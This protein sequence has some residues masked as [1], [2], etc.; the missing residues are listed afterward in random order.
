MQELFFVVLVDFAA[1]W[2]GNT[3][4]TVAVVTSTSS[5]T[6]DAAITF[7]AIAEIGM[8]A[9]MT[10]DKGSHPS[11]HININLRK[12]LITIRQA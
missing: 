6:A 11:I 10:P 2:Q 4:M 7:A 1:L 8:A 5:A 12:R 9:A 3:D